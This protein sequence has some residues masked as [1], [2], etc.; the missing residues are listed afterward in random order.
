MTKRSVVLLAA[1]MLVGALLVSP[2]GAH[3]TDSIDHLWGGDG[4]IK[5]KVKSLGDN[6]WADEG[7]RH[8][9]RYKRLGVNARIPAGKSITGVI[10]GRTHAPNEFIL[11]PISFDGELAS[12]PI[13][14]FVGEGDI[15][16]TEGCPG[17]VENP[18]SAPGYLCIYTGTV[19]EGTGWQGAWN[20][21]GGPCGCTR[22]A[23]VYDQHAAAGEETA[24][25]WS[26]TAPF[27]ETA[28]ATRGGVTPASSE[29]G[30]GRTN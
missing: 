14:E 6:R 4:H 13:V 5:D 7:H 29:T 26:V 8:D 9:R 18:L 22:G 21:T 11:Q 3:V 24:G 20:P 27:P 12:A 30:P 1:G 19:S 10:A 16:P 28:T 23:V 15:T 25:T 2:V 17:D